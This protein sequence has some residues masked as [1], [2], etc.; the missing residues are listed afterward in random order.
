MRYFEAEIE[1]L[2]DWADDLKAGLEREIKEIDRAIRD[3]K[4]AA[5]AAGTLEEKLGGQRQV[6]SLESQRNQKR[7][8]L[9]DAHDE[10]DRRR[11]TLI[12]E[13]EAKLGQRESV[14]RLFT[15][16]WRLE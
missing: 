7:R 13:I 10:V 6:K 3:A 9:F 12:A 14:R 11:E 2:D 16:R 5:K 4:K 1:K 15:V 8:T